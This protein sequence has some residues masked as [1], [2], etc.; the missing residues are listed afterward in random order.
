VVIGS[1]GIGQ[2]STLEFERSD[3]LVAG[4][5]FVRLLECRG[6]HPEKFLAGYLINRTHRTSLGHLTS[7]QRHIYAVGFS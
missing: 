2:R 1:L 7:C 6:L 3:D 5:Q 4:A